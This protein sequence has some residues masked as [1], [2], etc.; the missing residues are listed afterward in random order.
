MIKSTKTVL[1]IIILNYGTPTLTIDCLRSLIGLYR[2]ELLDSKIEILVVDNA[3][4]DNSVESI[5]YYASSIGC[6]GIIKL[7][8]NKGNVGFAGGCNIGAKAA[9]GKCILFLNSDTEVLD[10]GFLSMIDFLDKNSNV[11]ILGGKLENSDGST[12]RSCGK[13]YNLFNLLIMLL[14]LERFGFL[15]SSPSKIQKVDWV[16]GACMMVRQDIFEKLTGF[17]EKLFMYIEDMEVC[18]RANKLGFVTYFY[19]NVKLKHKSLGSSNKTF[20]II[21]IYKGILH[22]YSK[23]KTYLEYLVAK[24]L[25]ITKAGI[26]ILVGLLTFNSELRDRYQKAIS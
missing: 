24:S 4:T 6:D 21:N 1:S 10:K 16:S 11:A 5:E 25:L 9:K 3:S 17:D 26:L 18:F 2:Q 13:F 12:Q 14:G 19:P 15:R 7:I 23:H 22:F 20:A 8:Q